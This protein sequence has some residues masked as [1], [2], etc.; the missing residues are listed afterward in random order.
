VYGGALKAGIDG[1]RDGASGKA[2]RGAIA[3]AKKAAKAR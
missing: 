2:G 1:V 3:P